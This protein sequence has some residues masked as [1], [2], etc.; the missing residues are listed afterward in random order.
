M[1]MLIW[2]LAMVWLVYN[3]RRA[4]LADRPRHHPVLDALAA[5]ADTYWDS[6][7]EMLEG[8]LSRELVR[9]SIDSETYRRRMT[10]LT[11]PTDFDVGGHR[12][13][14]DDG[15]DGTQVEAPS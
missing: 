2:V 14:T 11:H 5:T 8:Q 12:N 9:G 6:P 3:A 7:E 10:E 13:V 15:H 4:M 1:A